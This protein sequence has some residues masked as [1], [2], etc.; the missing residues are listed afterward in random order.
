MNRLSPKIARI[1]LGAFASC[2]LSATLDAQVLSQ[3]E[4]VQRDVKLR[5]LDQASASPTQSVPPLYSGEEADSGNQ[6]L[7]EARPHQHWNWINLTLDSE[8]YYTSNAFLTNTGNKGTEL[9]INTLDAAIAAPPITVPYGQLFTRAGYQHQWFDYGIGGPG[10][11][12]GKLNFDAGT[13]Y[14]EAQ[15]ELP[16]H[17]EIF[18]NLTYTRLLSEDNDYSEFYK[19]LIPT[20]GVEKRLQLSKTV[21]LTIDYSGNYRFTDE[22]PFPGQ[23]RDC[24]N[25]TDQALALVLDWQA[26][27]K[28]IIRPFYQ[29]Q[30]SRY[31]DF[32]DNHGADQLLYT[33]GVSANYCFNSWSSVRLFL[34]YEIRH[35]DS[36]EIPDYRKLDAGGGLSV[37]LKF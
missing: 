15:Y 24:N 7:L 1:I 35:S 29:F 12:F 14:A 18:G 2:C 23:S 20:L 37:A 33:M 28:V 22:A 13:V 21:Q 27:P 3:I 34:S 31:P 4:Q 17:W 5:P 8:Y 11:H 30:Y 19:E 6:L 25:R 9:L 16:N 36:P 26:A 32:F 10:D